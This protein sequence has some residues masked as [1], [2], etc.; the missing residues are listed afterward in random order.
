MKKV[1][2][3]FCIL[4]VLGCSIN[5]V[6]ATDFDVIYARMYAKVL[7]N[8]SKNAV[9][10]IT[11]I[12]NADGSFSDLNYTQTASDLTV[13]LNRLTTLAAAYKYTGNTYNNNAVIKTKYFAGLN[14]WITKNHQPDNWWYR[15]IAYPKAAWPGVVLLSAELQAENAVLFNN[16]VTYLRWAY[17]QNNYMEGANGADKIAGAFPSSVLIK[18]DAQLQKYRT[19]IMGLIVVQYD[20]DGI[21]P[22]YMFGQ[23]SGTGRQ[24]YANY[25]IEYMRSLLENLSFVQGT[26][27]DVT[28]AELGVLEEHYI[29]GVQWYVYN[30]HIDPSQT[31]RK[32]STTGGYGGTK[33]NAANLLALNTPQKSAMAMVSDRIGN[34]S[35][36]A[37]LLSGNK[38]SWRF[39]YMIHRRPA[40]YISNRMASTRCV[41]MESGN[42]EGTTNYYGGSGLNFIFRT[43]KEYES[44]YFTVFNYRQWPGITVE[45]DNAALPLVDWGAGGLNGNAFAGGVSDGNYGASGFIYS[46]RNV[47][48]YKG[49]FY[50]ENELVAL[51]NG[52]TQTNGTASVFTTVNQTLQKGNITY[53]KNNT[54]QSITTASGTIAVTNPDWII[55][56]SVA[57]VNLASTSNFRISSDTRS[58][59]N[60]FTVGIDH[61]TNPANATYA[62]V[63]YPGTSAASVTSYKANI[64]VQ[65]I[66]NTKTVQAVYH[67]TLK[68]TQAIFFAAG[69]L[70]LADGKVVTVNAPSAVMIKD[71]NNT[72][73][74]SVSNPLCETSNPASLIVTFSTQLAGPGVSWN[75]TLSSVVFTL[76][77][78]NLAGKSVTKVF[79]LGDCIPVFAST[80]DGNIA[81]NTLDNDLAT[82]W[83]AN[84]DG[85]SL[86]FCVGTAKTINR[87]DI[88][89][90]SG[91]TRV[92]T[93][94]ILVSANG[95][96]WINT[97]LGLKSSGKSNALEAFTFAPQT[98]KYVKI[99]G[100][101]NSSS[102]W[103]SYAEVAFPANE[104]P[105]VSITSPANNASFNAPASITITAVATD[106]D[107]TVAQVQ[108]Y[109]GTTYL[110]NALMSPYT[111]TWTNVAQGT[112]KIS[113]KAIDNAGEVKYSSVNITVGL[114]TGVDENEITGVDVL[115]YPNPA[116]D[117]LYLDEKIDKIEMS[118]LNG[119][120]YS[121]ANR[122]DQVNIS[123]LN[124]GMYFVKLYLKTGE[125][126]YQKIL[127]N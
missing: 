29:Q 95:T 114:T 88:A 23:H 66:S 27:Y 92:S 80:D 20:G 3:L 54:Q 35:K 125:S 60:I 105:A 50:F 55:Q 116:T 13:H 118:D 47:T 31:G 64:P 10:A 42:G 74:I 11:A 84:G 106:N 16:A 99:V 104:L 73:K 67:K 32:P 25:E 8:P 108:F 71:T 68:I 122:N 124:T 18:S 115:I 85:Q 62:Y 81:E 123:E 24:L 113:A 40:Y 22:D 59:T 17:L 49:W 30:S 101:G 45:Q 56:D 91:D 61:G 89:F 109:N 78:G 83:S 43:G 126:R 90:Y 48:A 9:D 79:T 94:D 69:S 97:A 34:G 70:T 100:H 6:S 15:H 7:T 26:V 103:N 120:V 77:Q 121:F 4:T 36:A 65:V 57:Y 28:N 44:N 1:Y 127:K 86:T 72:Y 38:M 110:G 75:G 2:Y 111:F 107:G 21:E 53:S 19:Q 98:G 5:T 63:V 112:Y 41:G 96:T 93:F 117:V 33:V 14:Y 52:I 119:H 76:P 82:R 102:T 58:A 39:D 37:T 51:G 87:V 46:K 12:M